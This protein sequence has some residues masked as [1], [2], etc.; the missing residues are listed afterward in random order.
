M[1]NPYSMNCFMR[2]VRKEKQKKDYKFDRVYL[3]DS[4]MVLSVIG[5]ANFRNVREDVFLDF[6]HFNSVI[7][8]KRSIMLRFNELRIC[9]SNLC[10]SIIARIL[11]LYMKRTRN[12]SGFLSIL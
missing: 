8:Y 4:S 5:M 3:K 1:Y 9:C 11:E 12:R 2:D 7:Y 10:R 6:I